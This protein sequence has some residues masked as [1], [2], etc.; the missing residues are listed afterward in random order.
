[1][2][3]TTHSKTSTAPTTNPKFKK[4]DLVK[5]E[6]HLTGSLWK[7]LYGTIRRAVPNATNDGWQYWIRVSENLVPIYSEHQLKKVNSKHPEKYLF[8]EELFHKAPPY[9][10]NPV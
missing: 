1:M 4:G 7:R 3:D 8:K 9:A 6:D 10:R 2:K 5:I